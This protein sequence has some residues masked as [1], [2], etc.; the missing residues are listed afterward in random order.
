[1]RPVRFPEDLAWLHTQEITQSGDTE[2]NLNRPF[3]PRDWLTSK[4]L[5]ELVNLNL[6][7][8]KKAIKT[9]AQTSKTLRS[10]IVAATPPTELSAAETI[11]LRC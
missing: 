4:L 8:K 10:Q 7:L 2:M 5:I 9:L 11:A 1:M 3:R 6:K